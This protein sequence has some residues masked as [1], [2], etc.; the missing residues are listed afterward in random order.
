MPSASASTLKACIVS[1]VFAGPTPFGTPCLVQLGEVQVLATSQLFLRNIYMYI[2][3]RSIYIISSYRKYL[4]RPSPAL[5]QQHDTKGLTK[6]F[7]ATE[8][9]LTSHP[10]PLARHLRGTG[11]LVYTGRARSRRTSALLPGRP[12][13]VGGP[14][15]ARQLLAPIRPKRC[16]KSTHK[17][18]RYMGSPCFPPSLF[19]GRGWMA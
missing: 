15:G 8:N 17:N 16:S 13:S 2:Y 12:R 4:V 6:Y 19:H 9:V 3:V 7:I 5:P 18:H 1:S 14:A 11:I 10:T